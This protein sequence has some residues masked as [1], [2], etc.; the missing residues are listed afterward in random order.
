[1]SKT[2][3]KL[4]ERIVARVLAMSVNETLYLSKGHLHSARSLKEQG[5]LDRNCW[6]MVQTQHLTDSV[7]TT[8]FA[9]NGDVFAIED[10]Y[11]NCWIIFED[12]KVIAKPRNEANA[13]RIVA[14]L[15]ELRIA[16]ADAGRRAAA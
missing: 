9:E 7:N 10:I 3:T 5:F 12:R 15:K 16:E 4:Q 2:L 1:M 13:K 8:F 14:A 6:G 11:D